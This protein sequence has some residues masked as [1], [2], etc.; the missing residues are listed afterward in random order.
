MATIT[1]QL[2]PKPAIS[3]PNAPALPR[4]TRLPTNPVRK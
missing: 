4:T 2:P 1:K 3:W